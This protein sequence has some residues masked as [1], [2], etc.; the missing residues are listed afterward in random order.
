MLHQ[1]TREVIEKI[2]ERKASSSSPSTANRSLALIRSI[3]RRA[4]DEWEWVDHIPK[5][6]LYREPK[7]HIRFLSHEEARRL[8]E[9][10][11]EHLC[12]MA[13]IAL[14]TGLRQRNVSY[15]RSLKRGR[16]DS[17]T[18]AFGSRSGIRVYLPRK[19]G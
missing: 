18:S 16:A 17:I 13:H 2:A 9:E 5:V 19:T 4:K 8:L 7:Q 14:S 6:R 12:D 3:L 1:V 11:P 10:L 15:L